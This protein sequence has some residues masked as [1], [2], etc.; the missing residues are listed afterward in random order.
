MTRVP[1]SYDITCLAGKIL[2]YLHTDKIPISFYTKSYDAKVSVYDINVQD[3]LGDEEA[4]LRCSLDALSIENRARC[5]RL[6]HP[7]CIGN[8][9]K[10]QLSNNYHS[11]KKSVFQGCSKANNPSACKKCRYA[12]YYEQGQLTCLDS[13]PRGYQM[14]TTTNS[15]QGK[16]GILS[17]LA[18]KLKK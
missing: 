15:C 6:C 1:S 3:L 10:H 4:Q 11:N 12:E 9:N 13:C 14:N 8:L 2:L 18:I 5:D 16:R 17:K 7:N